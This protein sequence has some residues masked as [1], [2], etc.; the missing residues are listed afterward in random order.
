MVRHLFEKL[1]SYIPLFDPCTLHQHSRICPKKTSD[2]T[3]KD[4]KLNHPHSPIKNNQ[5]TPIVLRTDVFFHVPKS[6]PKSIIQKIPPLPDTQKILETR[7]DHPVD[8]CHISGEH[9]DGLKSPRS[10]RRPFFQN[11]AICDGQ[12]VSRACQWAWENS[13]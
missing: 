11:G 6:H 4:F 13:S 7:G 1:H 5:N 9:P 8:R 3:H 12:L 10:R 2:S